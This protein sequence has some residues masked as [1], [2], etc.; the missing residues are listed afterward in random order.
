MV[1]L[2]P[3]SELPLQAHSCLCQLLILKAP[4]RVFTTAKHGCSFP[5]SDRTQENLLMR[6]PTLPW[7]WAQTR[8]L[9]G[10]ISAVLMDEWF[11]CFPK[12]LCRRGAFQSTAIN[13]AVCASSFSFPLCFAVFRYFWFF[14]K[15]SLCLRHWSLH[16]AFTLFPRW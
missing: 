3:K 16:S 12:L 7:I 2:D 8:E 13:R 4:P 10:A 6:Q 11:C 15:W 1:H 14:S 9:W 5:S